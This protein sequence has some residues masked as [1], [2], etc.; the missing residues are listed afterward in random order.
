MP[1]DRGRDG[2]AARDDYGVPA[3]EAVVCRYGGPNYCGN[4]S[5]GYNHP[6]YGPH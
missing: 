2:N 3:F 1:I 6:V 4:Q 5:Y